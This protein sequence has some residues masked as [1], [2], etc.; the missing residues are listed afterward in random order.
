MGQG[1][2]GT[3]VAWELHRRG[4]SFLIVDA[5]KPHSASRVA[6]GLVTP[7]AGKRF[8]VAPHFDELYRRAKAFYG[9]VEHLLDRTFFLAQPA[10][11]FCYDDEEVALFEQ[12]E[13]QLK[14]L[15]RAH[16]IKVSYG[17][18]YRSHQCAVLMPGAARLDTGVYLDGSRRYFADRQQWLSGNVN[19]SSLEPGSDGILVKSIGVTAQRVVFCGGHQDQSNAW[20]PQGV[21]NCAKG[22]ILTVR[23]PG[24]SE[25][26]TIHARKRWLCPAGGDDHYLFGATYEHDDFS[27]GLS[28]EARDALDSRLKSIV[29]LPYEITDHSFGIRPIGMQ[30]KAIVGRSSRVGNIGWLNGLGS[31]GS[32][33][34][35]SLASVLIDSMLSDTPISVEFTEA[36]TDG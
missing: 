27:E 2:A 11:R 10:L 16:R 22:E 3:A 36:F 14:K 18:R 9:V 30:R 35:P 34:A 20:L 6:A 31:K 25:T 21:F 12:R 13:S 5:G 19:S 24:L 26:R 23:I 15:D 29:M 4:K 32:L 33:L 28:R 7:V 1:I 17:D 8:S